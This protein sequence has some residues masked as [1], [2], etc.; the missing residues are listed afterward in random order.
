MF[1]RRMFIN[2]NMLIVCGLV[3]LEFSLGIKRLGRRGY[4]KLFFND[5]CFV[6]FLDFFC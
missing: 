6:F 5:M 3:G 2:E 4:L 1:I